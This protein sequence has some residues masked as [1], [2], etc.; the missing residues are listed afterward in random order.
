MA[1]KS[2]TIFQISGGK[3]GPSVLFLTVIAE[4]EALPRRSAAIAIK[5]SLNM[6]MHFLHTL[7]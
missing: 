3:P 2:P 1:Q 6:R 7:H 5:A 4:A